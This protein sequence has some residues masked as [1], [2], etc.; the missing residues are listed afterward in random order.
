MKKNSY[1]AIFK[2]GIVENNPTLVQLIGMCPTLAVTTS[3]IN[4]LGMGAAV[5]VV[6]TFSNLFISLLRKIIPEQ[7]RIAA[8]IVVISGFVTAVELLLKAFLPSISASLGL[9]IPLIVVNC[10]ILARAEAFAS[11]NSPLASV[12]DGLAMG[13]GFTIALTVIGFI[14]E[15]LGTGKVFAGSDGTGGIALLGP[16]YPPA[17]V[18]V[19]PTGAFLTL[20]FIIAA[21]QWFRNSSDGKKEKIRVEAIKAQTSSDS[22]EAGE[23]GT[24]E[25]SAPASGDECETEAVK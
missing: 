20:S 25:A 22:P 13:A 8:Y 16:S 3:V 4:A 6:L 17:T 10:I 7:V 11:K 1:A 9:F 12:C 18:F 21:V 15:L 2:N 14:R 19:L 24:D 5:I 23:N